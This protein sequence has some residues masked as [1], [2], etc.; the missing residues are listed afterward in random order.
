VEK[1]DVKDVGLL[2]EL[3]TLNVIDRRDKEE[4]QSIENSIC[5][6]ERLLSMLS[7]TS[8]DQWEHFLLALERT[9]QQHLADM[10]RGRQTEDL[11]GISK[12]SFPDNVSL[13]SL[14]F[15]I[16]LFR[17]HRVVIGDNAKLIKPLK[18]I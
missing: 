14:Y 12:S 9:G 5:R 13:V 4:L 17:R 10:I 11:P 1:M 7:R 18:I 2:A 15:I 6:A 8:S 3:F 16:T